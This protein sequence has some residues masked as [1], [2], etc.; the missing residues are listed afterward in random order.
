MRTHFHRLL[1]CCL[2]AFLNMLPG[3]LRS[4]D[5]SAD[6]R[7]QADLPIPMR[8]GTPLSANLFLPKEG[9]SFPVILIRTPYGKGGE[10]F[11]EGRFYATRGYAVL[12]QDCRGRGASKGD[13]NPFRYDQ[14][15]GR[16]TQQWVGKQSWCNGRIGTAGG[17]YVGWTQWSAAPNSTP[18]LKAMAPGVPF[19]NAYD[20]AYTGG[21]FQLALLMGWGSAVGG[22]VPNPAASNSFLKFLPLSKWSSQL[23]K[24]VPYLDDWVAHPTYDDYWRQRGIGDSFPEVTVPI[25]NVGGWYDIFSRDTLEMADQVR[26]RSK[27]RKNRRN[28][29]VI[30][31]PWAHGV[32]ARK[33]GELDFGAVAELKVRE[34]ESKWFDYWLQDK[35]TDIEEWPALYLFVMGENRWRGENE[36]PLARTKFTKTYLHSQGKANTVSGDGFLHLDPPG[37]EPPDEF[38]YDPADP[39]PTVGGNNLVWATIGPYDQSKVEAR[40]DVLVYTS[41]VLNEPVEVTGPVILNLYASSSAP[42]TDFTAKLVDVYP[43]GKAYNLCEGIIRAR[44]RNSKVNLELIEPGKIYPYRI[45]LWVTSNL[46]KPGH[47]IRLEVSSSNFPR[48]DRNPN[49]EEPFGTGT[50]LVKAKQRIFHD[51]SHPSHLLLPVIPREK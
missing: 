8:D 36:W 31:G 18:Y 12:I 5:A 30:M 26:E 2:L 24:P 38:L 6:Y 10:N 22:A 20:L 35:E 7:F 15:D 11:G 49:T 1:A 33:V 9:D 21:A 43:D 32:G 48:F 44:F 25:L 23:S 3:R 16:D 46:F 51:P 19:C 41:R 45:D 14:E 28:Q 42:D 17:S 13:W 40:E 34:F 27:D 47:R 29:F 37:D 4:A 39:V 50:N